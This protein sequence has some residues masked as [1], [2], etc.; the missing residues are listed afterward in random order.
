MIEDLLK[1][2]DKGLVVDPFAGSGTTG[3]ACYNLLFDFIGFELDQKYADIA[4][5]RLNNRANQID[6]FHLE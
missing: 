2:F 5:D 3:I 1:C 6:I 4:N